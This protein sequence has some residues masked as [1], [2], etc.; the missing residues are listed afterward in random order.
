MQTVRE[1]CFYLSFI[2]LISSGLYELFAIAY[3]DVFGSLGIAFFA[4]KEGREAFE[5][6][7]SGNLYVECDDHCETVVRKSNCEVE[8]N[9]CL[10]IHIIIH[11]V[12]VKILI[13]LL[14][15]V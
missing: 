4:F 15:S 9:L 6:V 13:V 2:L 1:T 5:K 14:S 3:F 8:K 10:I 7:K 11:I 12:Q